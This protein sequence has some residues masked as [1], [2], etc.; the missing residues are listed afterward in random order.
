[1]VVVV[2]GQLGIN[3]RVREQEIEERS[4]EVEGT[5][6][7][8]DKVQGQVESRRQGTHSEYR[9]GPLGPECRQAI[10]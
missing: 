5:R 2:E 6:G 3:L 1:M 4:R 7:L 8:H 9:T 10:L